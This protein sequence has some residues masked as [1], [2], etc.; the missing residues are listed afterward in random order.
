MILSE[1]IIISALGALGL[2]CLYLIELKNVPRN[3]RPDFKDVIYWLPFVLSP[4]IAGLFGY[5][6][7]HGKTDIDT[8]LALHI[9]ISSPLL[10][11]TM[12]TVIPKFQN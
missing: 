11:R 2:Q 4:L 7:F 8:I 5:A 3:Q 6:Y 12:A 10:L 1:P 9:G